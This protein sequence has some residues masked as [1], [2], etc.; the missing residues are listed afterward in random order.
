MAISNDVSTSLVLALRRN[1]SREVSSAVGQRARAPPE[2]TDAP[3][4][5]L[6]WVW[7]IVDGAT[8][9]AAHGV[10]PPIDRVSDHERPGGLKRERGAQ[11]KVEPHPQSKTRPAAKRRAWGAWARALDGGLGG[12]QRPVVLDILGAHAGVSYVGCGVREI[13]RIRQE[14]GAGPRSASQVSLAPPTDGGSSG[15]LERSIA[16][17]TWRDEKPRQAVQCRDRGVFRRM[18]GTGFGREASDLLGSAGHRVR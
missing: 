4:P 5:W 12:E 9:G 17:S 8:A 6:E 16:D 2:S 7:T 14:A 10:G 18:G 13:V 3:C 1:S 11:L 15:R